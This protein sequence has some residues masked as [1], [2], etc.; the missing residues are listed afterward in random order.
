MENAVH[1]GVHTSKDTRHLD[2]QMS[3]FSVQTKLDSFF[4]PA[5]LRSKRSTTSET[6]VDE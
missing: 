1:N 5:L 3:H 6:H 4:E 2:R